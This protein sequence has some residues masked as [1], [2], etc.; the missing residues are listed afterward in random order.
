MF[1]YVKTTKRIRLGHAILEAPVRDG[2]PNM[3]GA[4]A[5]R[6]QSELLAPLTAII[7]RGAHRDALS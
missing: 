4:C 7:L 1:L 6:P 5:D 3:T 2:A